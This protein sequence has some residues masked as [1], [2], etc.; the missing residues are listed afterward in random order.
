MSRTP[1]D[2]SL[3]T[4]IPASND[5][6]TLIDS[7]DGFSIKKASF[8]MIYTTV[9]VTAA[10]LDGGGN[11][12]AFTASAGDQIKVEEIKLIGGGTSFGAGGDRNI[13]LTDGTTTYTT[14]ANADIESAPATTLRWGD[15]KVP[16]SAGSADTATVASQNLRFAYSGGTTDHGGVGSIKFRVGFTKVA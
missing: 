4:V 15:T 10:L 8:P 11:V 3:Q 1:A 7:S 13:S 2:A 9:T 16:F 5:F 14:I 12:A 6:I